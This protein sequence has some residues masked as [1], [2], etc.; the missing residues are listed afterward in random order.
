MFTRTENFK[1]F[2]RLYPM[3]T[4]IITIHLLLFIFSIAP[5]FPN[6][7]LFEKFMG[8]NLYIKEG[9]IWRLVTPIFMHS[10]FSHMLFNSFSLLLFGPGL[11][12]ILGKTKFA[13]CYLFTGIFANI[14]TFL[15]QPLTFT[16]VGSSGAIFGLFGIYMAIIIFRKDIL[17]KENAQII[18]SITVIG[19]VMT[20]FQNN[21]N[22]TGHIFG[23]LSGFVLGRILLGTKGA[24]S[25][26]FQLRK[27]KIFSPRPRSQFSLK[28]IIFIIMILLAIIGLVFR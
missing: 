3:V 8:V 5:I 13:L 20:F 6:L 15:F 4:L 26:S 11:E 28:H 21:I 18:L 27:T 17:S 19:F 23:L 7:W 1:E 16:H 12:R 24:P 22:V 9:D 2:I 10:G 14:A 25:F